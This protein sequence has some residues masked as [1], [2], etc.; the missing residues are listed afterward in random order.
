MTAALIFSLA[1]IFSFGSDTSS[2]GVILTTVSNVPNLYWLWA[3]P[4][5]GFLALHPPSHFSRIVLLLACGLAFSVLASMAMYEGG[6]MAVLGGAGIRPVL[7]IVAFATLCI[8]FYWVIDSGFNAL[9]RE[10]LVGGGS[11]LKPIVLIALCWLPYVLVFWPS[12][13]SSDMTGQLA[14]FYGETGLSTHHPLASTLVYGVVDC[15]GCLTGLGHGALV[16]FQMVCILASVYIVLRTIRTLAAPAWFMRISMIFFAIVP[17]FGVYC[18]FIVKDVIFG[19]AFAAYASLIMLL[20]FDNE[21]F[22]SLK[23][24]TVL[25]VLSACACGLLRN[26]GAYVV[27]LSL[28]VIIFLNKAVWPKKVFCALFAFSLVGVPLISVGLQA[29]TH[30]TS[31]NTREALSLPFQQI[32]RY[33][34]DAPDDIEEWEY[35]AVDE[36]LDIES[37][38]ERYVQHISDPVKNVASINLSNAMQFA[39]AWVSLGL[40]HPEIYLDAL[41]GQTSAYWSIVPARSY[42]TDFTAYWMLD[43][44]SGQGLCHGYAKTTLA[45]IMDALCMM[46]VIDLLCQPGTYTWLMLLEAGYLVHRGRFR[47]AAAYLPSAILLLTCIASPVNGLMR[48]VFG[49]VLI[50]PLMFWFAYVAGMRQGET[51][52]NQE[53]RP[54]SSTIGLLS[55][56]DE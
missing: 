17:I 32:A 7:S 14:Q 36:V 41:I 47:S 35:E 42:P 2:T 15:I 19:L 16:L 39:K 8:F 31:G 33:V 49:L 25:L 4:L 6:S 44:E 37:L 45:K 26:N 20:V 18:Q 51:E 46:P 13:P 53:Y 38:G 56:K 23:R 1:Y 22:V 10:H 29:A 12:S 43:T 24:N 9:D 11:S 54:K 3:I 52:V 50:A 30:A 5:V 34:R 28:P 21:Q 48:Y 40:R 55:I 27:V